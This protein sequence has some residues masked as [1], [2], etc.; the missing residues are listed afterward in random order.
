MA[1]EQ[2]R[3]AGPYYTRSRRVNG[4]V[5]RQY[6]GRGAL[7]ELAAY[8]DAEAR[9]ARRD[10]KDRWAEQRASH[11]GVRAAL[12]ALASQLAALTSKALSEAGYHEHR[13]QWRRRR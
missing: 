2:R 11:E 5:V 10:E 13:G 3:G 12:L 4:R 9:A 8:E 7:A 6:F 1:W